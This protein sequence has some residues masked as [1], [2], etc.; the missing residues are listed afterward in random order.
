MSVGIFTNANVF[1]VFLK[2][3]GNFYKA[4]FFGFFWWGFGGVVMQQSSESKNY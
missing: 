1:W 3:S 4:I 2:A